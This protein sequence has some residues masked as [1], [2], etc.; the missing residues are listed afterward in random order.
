VVGHHHHVH[1][2]CGQELKGEGREWEKIW[3]KRRSYHSIGVECDIYAHYRHHRRFSCDQE[4]AHPLS[5]RTDT[6][7]HCVADNSQF[8]IIMLIM[9]VFELVQI[10]LFA[11]DVNFLV[12]QRTDLKR[13][14]GQ[15]SVTYFYVICAITIAVCLIGMVD[16]L[17]LRWQINQKKSGGSTCF[18]ILRCLMGFFQATTTNEKAPFW[19]WL[20][21]TYM[22]FEKQ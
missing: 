19:S 8:A 1:C 22:I 3:K 12:P 9:M 7:D 11:L 13:K 20:F 17:L 2:L 18:P 14:Y 6:F 21:V 4:I 10:I 16:A 15:G 5:L